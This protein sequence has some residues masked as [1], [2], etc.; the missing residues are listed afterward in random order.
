MLWH[1]GHGAG[2]GG[3]VDRQPRRGGAARRASI[4]CAPVPPALSAEQ[5]R[6]A[7]TRYHDVAAGHY[8]SKWG[9][10]FGES[11]ARRC[12]RRSARRSA[13]SPGALRALARDRRRHRLLHAEPAARRGDRRGDVQRHLPG[14]ARV[15][16]G[17]RARL[18]FEVRTRARRRRAAAVRGRELRP[19][20]R[21]RGAP[22]HPRPA[23]RVRRVRARA[24]A[25]RHGAVRRR[26][27][28]LRRPPGATCPSASPERDRAAWRRAIGARAAAEPTP[29][30]ADEAL[31]RRRRR[32]RLRARA[33]SPAR[34]GAPGSR[35]CG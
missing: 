27:L 2:C 28:A 13:A 24:R 9:I 5:I 15:A 14:H 25:G 6:D 7:N 32:P 16:R 30:D 10:D 20:A 22:P 21:P 29:G 34:P 4:W 1:G 8:D 17:E 31:E 3:L 11:A 18:G 19:R 26:A 35:T 23:A 12:S 33:S